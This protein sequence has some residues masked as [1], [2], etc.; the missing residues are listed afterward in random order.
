MPKAEELVP[1]YSFE[2]EMGALGSM[3]L[4]SRAAEEVIHRLTAEDFYR[5]A[6]REVFLAMR[7]LVQS[8]K[9]IDVLTL[10][11]ELL[12]RGKLA[13]VGGMP[14][15]I[16]IAEFTPSPANATHYANIV[17]DK[18]TLRR[19][20]DAGRSI[21]GLVTSPEDESTAEDKVDRAE[22]LVFEV[23]RNR[24]GKDFQQVSSL[25]KEFFLDVDNL[26]ETG[27]PTIGTPTGFNDLDEKLSGLYPGDLSIVAARP[28]MGKTSLVVDIAL[29]VARQNIGNVA[30]FSLEMSGIQLVRRMASML[31]GV[32]SSTLKKTK[33]GKDDYKKLADACETLYSLP[34]YIDD[35]SDISG[36]EMRAKCRR[37]KQ[38]GGLALV[39]VDYLQ[40]MRGNRKTEN[41]VQEIGDIARS[42][43]A[44]AKDLEVPV[45]ALSQLNRAV[46]LRENKRP[47]LSDI[48]ESGS[49]EAEAD[50][51][52]M[53]YRDQYYR[54]RQNPG[55]ANRDPDRTEVTE[56]NVVKHR[57]GDIGIVLLAFQPS[58]ARFLGLVKE[59]Q[60]AYFSKIRQEEFKTMRDR[61]S[62]VASMQD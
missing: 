11:E 34:L 36:L 28:S 60:H 9:P 29:R 30:V 23:G 6:H 41:R 15:L 1:L 25:A 59:D 19:L 18:A 3:I 45:I 42:L 55:E 37:L 52:M 7:Q 53:I 32:S 48:R 39:V 46:E 27:Q 57:N 33:L 49:I 51:V 24:L 62:A 38:D 10:K 2:A 58:Y 13:D 5:P 54:D 31:S 14:Y 20:G 16:E 47:Q 43:K 26:I 8:S 4:S 61:P 17:L 21:V 40:L 44:L 56:I 12:A 35:S 22:Q 50:V